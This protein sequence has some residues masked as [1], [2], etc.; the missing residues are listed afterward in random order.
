MEDAFRLVHRVAS[1][2]H[3]YKEQQAHAMATGGS[4]T[5]MVMSAGS[6]NG[7]YGLQ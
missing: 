5:R 4:G 2:R 3:G 7:R 1:L 6:V